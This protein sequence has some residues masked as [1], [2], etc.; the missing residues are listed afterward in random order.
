MRSVG[1]KVNGNEIIAVGGEVTP[2]YV[3]QC[4][5]CGKEFTKTA[6]KLKYWPPKSCGCRVKA[7]HENRMRRC[8]PHRQRFPE[9]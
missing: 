5:H 4:C 7:E 8:F 3:L 1:D 6:N 2:L 9:R